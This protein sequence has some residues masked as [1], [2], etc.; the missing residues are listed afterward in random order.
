MAVD[1]HFRN[2]SI[3]EGLETAE[4]ARSRTLLDILATRDHPEAAKNA[5]AATSSLIDE[6]LDDD[7]P[8]G[9]EPEIAASVTHSAAT[10][11][12][13]TATAK[14]L[15]S[16][17][18]SYW[19]GNESLFLWTVTQDG[20]VNG[21]RVNVE[22]AELA[23][24]AAEAASRSLETKKDVWRELYRYLI[25]PVAAN[26]P[27]N[28]RL[29]IIPHGPLFRIPFAALR[30]TSNHYLIE[31]YSLHYVSAGALL[32]LTAQR[33]NTTVDVRKQLL[34]ADPA[35][36][37]PRP[38]GKP[39]PPLAG[40]RQEVETIASLLPPGRTTILSGTNA[41]RQSLLAAAGDKTVL[42]FATHGVIREDAPFDSFLALAKGDRLTARE[43]YD[44]KLPAQLVVLSA[45]RSGL[46]KVSGE[47]ILGL[48]RAFYYAGV[49]GVVASLWDVADE[50]AAKLLTEFYRS[51]NLRHDAMT[52]LRDAQLRVLQL[53]RAG[54]IQMQ[55]AA[56][57]VTLPEQPILWAG[58][59]LQGEP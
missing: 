11:A 9:S 2:N 56:G 49:P 12:T 44:W 58:F 25:Q 10:V 31:K 27:P 16:T 54:K 41:T 59:T 19:C 39:L 22:P 7:D 8:S 50:P 30:D 24:L 43:I 17:I 23:R 13:L 46:G 51:Y 21:A 1:L 4:L 20:I 38:D 37:P 18:V 28:G 40:S 32:D 36:M 47:G 29:T 55:T 15:N 26:L 35:Q 34:V 53:L 33:R 48:T 45:C 5:S 42:H 6:I 57:P 14:R 3:A 52:A